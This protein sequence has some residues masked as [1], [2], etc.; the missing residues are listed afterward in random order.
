MDARGPPLASEE[1]TTRFFEKKNH[2]RNGSR[3]YREMALT[4]LNVPDRLRDQGI[5]TPMAQGLSIKI[6][7]TIKWIRTSRLSIKK[8]L[9][10]ASGP[11]TEVATG[12]RV[13][14]NAGNNPR[15]GLCLQVQI[16]NV[17]RML[18]ELESRRG[19]PGLRL[20]IS[21]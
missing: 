7:S 12:N 11:S 8:S 14:V 21:I 5:Q 2:L 6:I 1:G 20:I 3:Q 17:D 4:G 16:W 19:E 15:P 9:S 18:P 10:E 13:Q